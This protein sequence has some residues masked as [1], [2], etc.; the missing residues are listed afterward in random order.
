MNRKFSLT[1]IGLG[2]LLALPLT[3]LAGQGQARPSV[4]GTVVY[5]GPMAFGID[6]G[7]KI[8]TFRIPPGAEWTSLLVPTEHV[9]VSW[10]KRPGV[11]GRTVVSVESMPTKTPPAR[12]AT[13][14][15]EVRGQVAYLTPTTLALE[16]DR[17]IEFFEFAKNSPRPDVDPGD[18]VNVF[19]RVEPMRGHHVVSRAEVV[20]RRTAAGASANAPSAMARHAAMSQPAKLRTITGSVVLLSPDTVYLDTTGGVREFAIGSPS[21]LQDVAPGDTIQVWYEIEN[22]SAVPHIVKHQR[23]TRRPSA[24]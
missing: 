23:I 4:T 14:E 19:Y 13:P 8:E 6:T 10:E 18:D 16:T 20:R 3:A 12:S 15:R 17:G 5:V 22:G 24:H 1:A 2:L 9:K 21:Q 7:T 11:S